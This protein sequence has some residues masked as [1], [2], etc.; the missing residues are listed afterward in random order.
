[1]DAL[2]LNPEKTVIGEVIA[3]FRTINDPPGLQGLTATGW[4][5]RITFAILVVYI[6]VNM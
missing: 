2:T 6:N 5:T 3:I 1:M 4:A